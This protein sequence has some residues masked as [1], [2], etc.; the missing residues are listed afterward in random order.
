MPIKT[1]DYYLLVLISIIAILIRLV[2][3][4]YFANGTIGNTVDV[5]YVD[6]E[7]AKL[8]LE[9]QDPYLFSNYTNH[10]G[11][12]VTFA[13]MPVIPA[14]YAP[15]LVLASDI[16]IGNIVADVIIVVAMFFIGRSIMKRE[17]FRFWVA[18]SGS[19]AY[20]ILPTSIFLTS[21]SGTNMMI[22][23]MFLFVGLAALFEE[24]PSIAGVFIGVALAA[25]QFII[26]IFP[27]VALY[28]LRNH[29]LKTVLIS[30]S[31]AAMI[32]LPF[33]LYSP[34]QFVYDAFTFQFQRTMQK[35]G[36]WDLYYLVYTLSGFKLGTYLRVAIFIV[37][38]SFASFFFSRKKKNDLLI[39]SAIVSA[40]ASI[41]L[42][43]DGFWN[44]FLLPFTFLC[45]L[46]PSILSSTRLQRLDLLHA[47]TAPPKLS[48]SSPTQFD[49]NYRNL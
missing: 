4:Y 11:N 26:L 33:M 43:I 23:S 22:G 2:S 30:A 20:A 25:N 27:L 28:C 21:V 3:M 42:P 46:V 45:A 37:P 36:V 32:I 7:S 6:R 19:I 14:Y 18:F 40:L 39:G 12:L 15:F 31:V 29:N 49:E 24:R 17:N 35:N 44:Y 34:S 38:A 47:I 41:V 9:F 1:R 10:L 16:R 13:Y 48:I 8:I 5:Y